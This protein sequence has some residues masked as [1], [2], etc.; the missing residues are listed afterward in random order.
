MLLLVFGSTVYGTL[1]THSHK[2]K[3]TNKKS[4]NK[5]AQRQTRSP[6]IHTTTSARRKVD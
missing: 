2:D 5:S 6:F 4:D 3:I 1:K